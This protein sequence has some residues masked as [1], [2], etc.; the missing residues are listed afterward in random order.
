MRG[1]M[2]Y[3][4][5]STG[6]K[7]RVEVAIRSTNAR[8]LEITTNLSPR[9]FSLEAKVKSLIKQRIVR[10]RIEVYFFFFPQREAE[11]FINRD[12]LTRYLSVY[13]QLS[14]AVPSLNQGINFFSLPG[15]AQISYSSADRKVGYKIFSEALKQL[16]FFKEKEGEAIKKEMLNSLEKLVTLVE[17]ICE[18]Q[19]CIRK[20]Y[21]NSNDRGGE[22]DFTEEV[23]LILFYAS[24]LRKLIL[25]N[26]RVAKGKEIDFLTQEVLREINAA[27]SKTKTKTISW[28]LVK[29]KSYLERIREQAQNVE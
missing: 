11:I 27:A 28:N 23:S 18:R 6:G 21:L 5:A 25:S 29:M 10:G 26:K 2:A 16:I 19:K 14:K 8:Y 1:M 3:G 20:Y 7:E 9:Q 13:H 24:N 12:I 22:K 15:V 4:F 17:L